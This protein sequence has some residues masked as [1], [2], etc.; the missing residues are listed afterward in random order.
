[1]LQQ[2]RVVRNSAAWMAAALLAIEATFA[3]IPIGQPSADTWIRRWSVTDAGAPIEISQTISVGANGLRAITVW[4]GSGAVP[5][6]GDVHIELHQ[7]SADGNRET[8]IVARDVTTRQ[9]AGERPYRLEF[10]ELADSAG[11]SYRLLITQGET[12]TGAGLAVDAVKGPYS[13]PFTIDGTPRWGSLR[14]R[15]EVTR[16]RWLSRL[17]DHG[18]RIHASAAAIIGGAAAWIALHVIGFE[19][20]RM[21]ATLRWNAE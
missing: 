20:I 1:M 14:Y 4:P 5:P 10:P 19:A 17:Q 21:A 2:V 15:T 18:R 8:A 16:A 6:A 3:V 12:V 7:L 11:R 9:F 13:E